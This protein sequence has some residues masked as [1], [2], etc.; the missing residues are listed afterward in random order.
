MTAAAAE[1][2]VDL[3]ML[4]RNLNRKSPPERIADEFEM[5]LIYEEIS[6][7]SSTKLTMI[8]EYSLENGWVKEGVTF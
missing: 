8:S 1:E 4:Q 6:P 5:S 7:V 3:S 2:V